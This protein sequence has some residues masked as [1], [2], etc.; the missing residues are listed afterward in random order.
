[1]YTWKDVKALLVN[2]RMTVEHEGGIYYV[3]INGEYEGFAHDIE[4]LHGLCSDLLA[5]DDDDSDFDECDEVDQLV[6]HA[7]EDELLDD[8]A[9]PGYQKFLKDN[10]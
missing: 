1:M 3:Y 2:T 9:W 5:D 7:S 4:D 10:E 8:E 6:E